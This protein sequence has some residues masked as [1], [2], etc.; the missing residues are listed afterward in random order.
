MPCIHGFGNVHVP[1][2]CGTPG[3]FHD[4]WLIVNTLTKHNINVNMKKN[5]VIAIIIIIL[6]IILAAV[7]FGIWKLVS[8]AKNHMSVTGSGTSSSHSSRD[9]AD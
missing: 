3:S 1:W 4:P 9:I 7:S 2:K 5:D 6:F 8:M